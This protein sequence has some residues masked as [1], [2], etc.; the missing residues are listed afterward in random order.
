MSSKDSNL[1]SSPSTSNSLTRV[2][3]ALVFSS[4]SSSCE[5]FVDKTGDCF[6]ILMLAALSALLC[7]KVIQGYKIA[8]LISSMN[9]VGTSG[10]KTYYLVQ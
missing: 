5:I 1:I 6:I 3:E 2:S 7:S 4:F 8:N 9:R 10:I